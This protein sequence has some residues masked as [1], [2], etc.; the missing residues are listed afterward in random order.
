M[1][2][3]VSSSKGA[4]ILGV[5]I[6]VTGLT[7]SFA[8][9][10]FISSE[11]DGDMAIAEEQETTVALKPK[12]PS[13]P[14]GWAES[15]FDDDLADDWGAAP[16]RATIRPNSSRDMTGETNEESVFGDY[17][18]SSSNAPEGSGR[19]GEGRVFNAP[20]KV[21]DAVPQSITF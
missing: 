10:N 6:V 14:S 2:N 13:S 1:K 15:G 7:L 18:E 11:D 5:V 4:L 9:S 19:E 17:G 21:G 8:A 12:E 3:L 20:S 16:T